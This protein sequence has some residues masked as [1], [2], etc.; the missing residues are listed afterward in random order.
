MAF[1]LFTGSRGREPAVDRG[2]PVHLH[3]EDYGTQYGS[4]GERGPHAAR[5]SDTAAGSEDALGLVVG[6]IPMEL[7]PG[8]Q[9]L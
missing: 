5:D 4:E 7:V 3:R 2:G 8:P 1:P 6:Y 9:I